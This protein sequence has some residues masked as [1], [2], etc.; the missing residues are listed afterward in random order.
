[1]K[2]VIKIKSNNL[3]KKLLLI[4]ELQI[5]FLILLLIIQKWRVYYYFLDIDGGI[6]IR[7]ENISIFLNFYSYMNIIHKFLFFYFQTSDFILF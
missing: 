5:L 3:K 7:W 1:M 4:K 2:E 6:N